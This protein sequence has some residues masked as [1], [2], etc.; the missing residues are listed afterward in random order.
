LRTNCF[1]GLAG[2]PP[3]DTELA[4]SAGIDMSMRVSMRSIR[5]SRA[6]S[7]SLADGSSSRA[8]TTSSSRRGAVAP[9]ISP[10]PACTTSA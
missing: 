6:D 9:L 10:R 7:V 3:V 5:C 4:L 8:Q 2:G 1:D